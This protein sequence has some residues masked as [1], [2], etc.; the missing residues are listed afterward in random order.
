[1][2]RMKFD[3]PLLNVTYGSSFVRFWW[4][5]FVF[6]SEKQYFCRRLNYFSVEICDS[7]FRHQR[8][9]DRVS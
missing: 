6:F 1:M 8:R 9:S 2:N 7:R 4:T 5:H 3:E